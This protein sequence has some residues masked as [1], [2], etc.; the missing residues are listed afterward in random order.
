MFRESIRLQRGFST[1]LAMLLTGFLVTL[2]AGVLYLFLSENRINQSL[3]KGAAAY[4][5]AEGA[6]EYALLKL[7]NHRE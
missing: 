7:K 3:F 1:I 2:T 4:H 5:A 6:L